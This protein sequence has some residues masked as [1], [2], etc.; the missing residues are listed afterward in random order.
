MPAPQSQSGTGCE[1]IE[2]RAGTNSAA[3][4]AGTVVHMFSMQPTCSHQLGDGPRYS[5]GTSIIMCSVK[6]IVPSMV[7]VT[8]WGKRHEKRREVR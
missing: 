6:Q 2:P 3:N 8:T 1:P 4:P 7:L 5:S